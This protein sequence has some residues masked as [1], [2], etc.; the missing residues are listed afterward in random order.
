MYQ[1]G[2]PFSFRCK[3]YLDYVK[4]TEIIDRL[5]GLNSK[6][7]IKYELVSGSLD[8]EEEGPRFLDLHCSSPGKMNHFMEE[9]EKMDRFIKEN[10]PGQKQKL[11]PPGFSKLN[12]PLGSLFSDSP[13]PAPKL[14]IDRNEMPSDMGDLPV[15]SVSLYKIDPVTGLPRKTDTKGF[16]EELE[17]FVDNELYNYYL[18]NFGRPP[19]SNEKDEEQ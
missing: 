19:K 15:A 9:I 10:T 5:N 4:T 1:P 2:Q 14:G 18:D 13:L 17:K 6:C 7:P 8:P 3:N 12:K 11:I 16:L